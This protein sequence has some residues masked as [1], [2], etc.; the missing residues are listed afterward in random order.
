MSP[1]KATVEMNAQISCTIVFWYFHALDG[2][3][4]SSFQWKRNVYTVH[5]SRQFTNSKLSLCDATV[6]SLWTLKNV[7][8]SAK[9]DVWVITPVGISAVNNKYKNGPRI[10]SLD[11]PADILLREEV[12]SVDFIWKYLSHGKLFSNLYTFIGKNCVI[13]NRC[14]SCQTLSKTWDTYIFIIK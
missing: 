1:G 3:K 12:I 10:L 11:T 7:V 8:S 14:P 2:R 6:E 13:L 9:V 5:F 4:I